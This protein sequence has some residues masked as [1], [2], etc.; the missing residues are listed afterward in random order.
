MPRVAQEFVSTK[1]HQ[2]ENDLSNIKFKLTPIDNF[3]LLFF[4]PPPTMLCRGL[5]HFRRPSGVSFSGNFKVPN[6]LF[7]HQTTKYLHKILRNF[8]SFKF[9]VGS[10]TQIYPQI[11][12]CCLRFAVSLT[13]LTHLLRLAGGF[14]G[15]PPNLSC[16][17]SR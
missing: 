9:I 8:L 14:S 16:M 13:P 11:S 7:P 6:C 3:P 10:S 12:S 4:S 2:Y 5:P 1:K 15:Y 17:F